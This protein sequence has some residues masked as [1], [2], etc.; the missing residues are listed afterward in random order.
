MWIME[1]YVYILERGYVYDD[2]T[3][4]SQKVIFGFGGPELSG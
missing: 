4:S 2:G 1:G 3:S